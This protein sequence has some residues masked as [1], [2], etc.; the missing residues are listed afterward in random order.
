MLGDRQG[1]DL[2]IRDHTARVADHVRVPDRKPKDRIR[3][4]TRVHTGNDRDLLGGR[5]RQVALVKTLGKGLVVPQEL[6]DDAH[7]GPLRLVPPNILKATG[8]GLCAARPGAHELGATTSRV[9]S[10]TDEGAMSPAPV[11][12]DARRRGLPD[13]APADAA[14][15][16]RAATPATIRPARPNRASRAADP[17]L[18][19]VAEATAGCCLA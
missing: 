4:Q 10:H 12:A 15:S 6:V 9:S 16:E 8:F 17:T 13:R 7:S 11:A 1:A 18:S 19:L 5:Q 2:V 3:I 14:K